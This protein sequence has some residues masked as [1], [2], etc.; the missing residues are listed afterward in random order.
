MGR[1][2]TVTTR[3][4][5]LD[6]LRGIAILLVMGRHM[7]G[8]PFLSSYGAIGVDLFFV[9]SGFLI[10]G[11]LF[12]E[13]KRTGMI[14]V[15]RFWIRRAFKIYPSYYA[16]MLVLIAASLVA[17]H[18][19]PLHIANDL[20]FLQGYRTHVWAGGWSI[21]IEE[22]FY[23]ALPLIL[24]ALLKIGR[25]RS[26][27][28]R[29][30]PVI[31]IVLSVACLYMRLRTAAAVS[32]W[33][34]VMVPT[35]LRIDSM[36]AG[37]TLGYF[38]AFD[39]ESF[40]TTKS[41]LLLVFGILMIAPGILIPGIFPVGLTFICVGFS[42]I[43]AWFV[44]RPQSSSRVRRLLAMVGVYSYSI[45]LWEVVVSTVFEHVPVHW[46]KSPAYFISAIAM[47]VIMSKLIEQPMLRL[48]ERCFQG[49]RRPLISAPQTQHA[50]G[51]C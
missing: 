46:W 39:S 10:S 51:E 17:D 36:F 9:L 14:D 33:G 7:K 49:T 29:L 25:R 19:M 20:F 42:C 44:N 34:W 12:A 5:S 37:V 26:N 2:A 30:I 4:Q 6:V 32:D 8:I 15:K 3:N 27:P 22:H 1:G 13:F 38:A 47:G 23:L 40:R 35:H 21:A 16:L 18:A 45:Y 48:R 28:F 43:L 24:L 11:L 31:S 41:S 50:S